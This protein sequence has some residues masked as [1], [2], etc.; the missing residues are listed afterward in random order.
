MWS[1]HVSLARVPAL[2]AL[3]LLAE[4]GLAWAL[5]RDDCRARFPNPVIT[6]DHQ[7]AEGRIYI[8]VTNWAAYSNDLFRAAPELPPCGANANSAR[9]WVDIYD[10]TT[11]A[12]IYGFCALGT[13]ADLKTIWFKPS[14]PNGKVY[15]IIND[16]ACK[17]SYRSN[18]IAYENCLWRYPN[19]T[20]KAGHPDA[21]GGISIPVTNWAAYDNGLFRAAPELPPCG[22]NAN[23]SRA[24]VDVYDATT[25]AHLLGFCGFRTNAD[26]KTVWFKPNSPK[27]Q[28]YI[29]INDR[30]CQ[31]QYR[32]NVVPYRIRMR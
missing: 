26:L 7:D 27:G 22:A 31:K 2:L 4:L 29:I 14:S 5:P 23:S 24:W 11:N 3:C 17:R 6:F 25:N 15:I 18:V 8:P 12:R 13:N 19:P 28:V 1:R 16:R 20:I 30:A 21:Q 9:A 32:S 10:A